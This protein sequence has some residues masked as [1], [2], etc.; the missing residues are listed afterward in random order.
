MILLIVFNLYRTILIIIPNYYLD[1]FFLFRNMSQYSKSLGDVCDDEKTK[2]KFFDS[3]DIKIM[4]I[5]EI[6]KVK[7]FMNYNYYVDFDECQHQPWLYF[8]RPNKGE[9]LN[10]FEDIRARDKYTIPRK[11]KFVELF[12]L[13]NSHPLLL[14][15]KSKST[16]LRLMLI[17]FSLISYLIFGFGLKDRA[18]DHN[19]ANS[20]SLSMIFGGLF[21]TVFIFLFFNFYLLPKENHR[22]NKLRRM[23]ILEFS[24]KNFSKDSDM[25]IICP[26]TGAFFLMLFSEENYP[27]LNKLYDTPDSKALLR[28]SAP[29]NSNYHPEKEMGIFSE[30]YDE[31]NESFKQSIFV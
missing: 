5:P 15:S 21:L 31:E 13:L 10:K 12:F 2:L 1:K 18:I 25:R 26:K 7:S 29:S 14:Q 17:I 27:F 8:I 4:N 28:R 30:K 20:I 24:Y 19:F 6:R 22:F 3:D 9:S 11:E 23:I 16:R